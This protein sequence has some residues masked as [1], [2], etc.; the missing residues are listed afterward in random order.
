MPRNS[1]QNSKWFRNLPT[2]CRFLGGLCGSKHPYFS[3]HSGTK[4][5]CNRKRPCFRG[6]SRTFSFCCRKYPHL[7]SQIRRNAHSTPNQRTKNTPFPAPNLSVA[8]FA[9]K[10]APNPARNWRQQHSA[11]KKHPFSR[12]KSS[13]S[14]LRAENRPKSRAAARLH[15]RRSNKKR[16]SQMEHPLSCTYSFLQLFVS[17][18]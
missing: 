13:R 2:G 5:F 8:T 17:Y 18:S 6:F 11:H 15:N 4:F 9:R 16:M 12:P 7:S 1:S 3:V 14:N 10:I